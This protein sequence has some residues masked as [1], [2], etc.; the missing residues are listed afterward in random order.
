MVSQVIDNTSVAGLRSLIQELL[1]SQLGTFANGRKAIAVEP[2]QVPQSGVGLH[3]YISRHAERLNRETY[4]YKVSLVQFDTSEIG[5][6]K[7]DQAIALMR[8]AFPC[9]REIIMP[10]REEMF[11]QITFF[12]AAYQSFHTPPLIPVG[13]IHGF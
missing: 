6:Q 1:R 13:I 2:P 9:R 10:Y 11:P 12:L 3:I 7:L 4:Q 5:L 8:S